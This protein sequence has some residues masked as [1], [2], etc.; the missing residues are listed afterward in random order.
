MI[1]TVSSRH[2]E[3]TEPMK[4]YAERKVSK[5]DRYYDRIQEIEVV[6]TA[7]K[8][9]IKVQIVVNGEQ[10]NMFIATH[11]EGDAYACV[12]ACVRKLER[13]LGDHNK[14]LKDRN[15]SSTGLGEATQE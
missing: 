12:D 5:L 9:D 6:F 13:Q 1:V 4:Q 2:M 7:E 11:S 15:I 8:G 10:K 14:K 3:I